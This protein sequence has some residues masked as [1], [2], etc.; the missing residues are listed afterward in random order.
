MRATASERILLPVII[1]PKK[2]EIK[3]RLP[4][5]RISISPTRSIKHMAEVQ[6]TYDKAEV[7]GALR[8]HF[9]SRKETKI[10]KGLCALLF[11]FALWGYGTSIV[12][13]GLLVGVFLAIVLLTIVFWFVL[14]GAIYRKA[15]T[16]HEPTIKFQYNGDG[17]AIGTHA[18]AKHLSWQSFHRVLETNDFFYL[19]RNSNSFFLIP[20]KAFSD[21]G[22]RNSFSRLLRGH[23]NNYSFKGRGARQDRP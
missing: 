22:E 18:G 20:T 21:E 4:V 16:F 15:K 10:L 5:Y 11:I 8:V 17:V 19:Y 3:I 6:F 12:S 14:P 23:I 1:L 7:I 13:Y 2:A 9:L